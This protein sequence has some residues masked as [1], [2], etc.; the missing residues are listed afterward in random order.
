MV[1]TYLEPQDVERLEEAAEY[2]RDRLLIRLLFRLGCRVSEALGITVDDIDFGEGTVT[3]KHLK[4]RV[5]LSCPHCGGRLARVHKFCPGCGLDI[6]QALSQVR[7]QRRF[8]S[9]PVDVETME[10]LKKYI[11]LNGPRAKGDRLLLFGINRHRAWQIVREC[12]ERAGLPSL[13]S[14]ESGK[15]H[16]VSPHR[17]RDAFAIHAVKVNDSGDAIR[18]LQEHLGHQSITTTMRYRKVSGEEQRAWYQDLWP[19]NN[20]E[21]GRHG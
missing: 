21:G 13:K 17:L 14:P 4:E 20:K 7:E 5:R 18:M 15:A 8:R 9:L 10:M 19:G 11:G 3:I 6:D 1:K 16:N 2:D 12:A